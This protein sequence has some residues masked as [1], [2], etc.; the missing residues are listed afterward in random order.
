MSKL[1]NKERLILIEERFIKGEMSE[2]TSKYI[3]RR[4]APSPI[5]PANIPDATADTKSP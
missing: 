3:V 2:E 1:T 4:P 5:Q